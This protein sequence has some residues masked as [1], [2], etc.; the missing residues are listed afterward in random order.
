MSQVIAT[1]EF[2]P[3][4]WA[5]KGGLLDEDGTADAKDEKEAKG[6]GHGR[7][8]AQ[9]A[10]TEGTQPQVKPVQIGN[11]LFFKADGI[12]EDKGPGLED[13]DE[14]PGKVCAST[15]RA[16]RRC[17]RLSS[18][19]NLTR[20]KQVGDDDDVDDEGDEEEDDEEDEEDEEEESPFMN[21][22]LAKL[23]ML[24]QTEKERLEERENML[25]AMTEEERQQLFEKEE[26]A[27]LHAEA[28]NKQMYD[29]DMAKYGDAIRNQQRLADERDK[30]LG[31]AQDG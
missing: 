26:K 22:M 27:R 23:D 11:A 17:S 4:D 16:G 5:A 31:I 9:E 24:E 10:W 21:E 28:L 29:D 13:G 18:L 6:E 2:S 7:P 14:A 25:A 30:T 8:K 1:S 20:R 12:N 3:V 15:A 19:Q